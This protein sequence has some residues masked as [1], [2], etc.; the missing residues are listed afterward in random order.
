MSQFF[1]F[2]ILLWSF[3]FELYTLRFI[4]GLRTPDFGLPLVFSQWD[5]FG[6]A[7]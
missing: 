7:F 3:S 4:F 2:I 6:A 5:A 1:F